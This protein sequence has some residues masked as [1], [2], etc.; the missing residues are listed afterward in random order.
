[1]SSG[2]EATEAAL[3]LMRMYGESKVKGVVELYVFRIIGMDAQWE[4]K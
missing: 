1:M 2:T 4:L 3:K